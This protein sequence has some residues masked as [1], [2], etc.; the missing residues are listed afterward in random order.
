MPGKL[1]GRLLYRLVPL[2][3]GG[4]CARDERRADALRD[5]LL[6]DH[7]LRDVAAGWQLEHHVEQRSL[8]DRAEAARAGLALE[9]A[10]GDLPHRVIGEDE[11]YPVV[12]EEALVLLDERV[13]GLLENLDEVFTPQLVHRG[14]DREPAD[15][16]RDQAEVEEVF[17][18]HLGEQ[19]RGFDVVLRADVGAEP[20]G[21]L[22]DTPRDDLVDP[23]ERAAAD[24]EDVGGVDREE[25]LMRVLAPALR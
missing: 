23:G 20:E 18:H 24:E 13:L 14:D 15:E 16:L 3:A 9:R 21:V 4:L 7:A 22:A 5:A 1:L 6:R 10:V 17:R 12:A 19:L 8:D 25:L 11:L 2:V